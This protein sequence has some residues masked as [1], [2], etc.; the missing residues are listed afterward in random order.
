MDHG[1]LAVLKIKYQY[2]LLQTHTEG[3]EEGRGMLENLKKNLQDVY[4][5]AQAGENTEQK[6][7]AR[8]W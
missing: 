6:V 2:S 7:L 1:V 3:I 8:S 4:W 5:T